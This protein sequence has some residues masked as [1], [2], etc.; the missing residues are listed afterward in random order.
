MTLEV[1]RA[2][3]P[4]GFPSASALEYWNGVLYALGDDSMRLYRWENARLRMDDLLL[5]AGAEAPGE[6]IPKKVKPDFEMLTVADGRLLGMGS[7]SKGPERESA[8]LFD[9]KTFAFFPVSAF[10]E[11]VEG[12]VKA[13]GAKKTNFEGLAESGGKLYIFHRGGNNGENFVF[14]VGFDEFVGQKKMCITAA[15]VCL[16][17]IG[18]GKPGVT[19]ATFVRD[20][21][22]LLTAAVEI[23]DD[24]VLDGDVAESYLC[25]W[26]AADPC[27]YDVLALTAVLN[28]SR[29]P[30]I[31]SVALLEGDGLVLCADDDE[32]GSEL[33]FCRW[34][35]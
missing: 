18:K 5:S 19:G 33:F 32:G 6:R 13:A 26:R 24:P 35:F 17:D 14:I 16:P 25:L 9:G 15:P 1:L 22:F 23:T 31:E 10:R 27:P 11:A 20:D 4:T 8:F 7:C 3:K 30:K 2:E 29:P 21:V 12:I 28:T 34:E